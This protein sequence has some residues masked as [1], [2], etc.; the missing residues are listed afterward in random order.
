MLHDYFTLLHE[1]KHENA[2]NLITPR[3]R[4]YFKKF[5]K[6]TT[7]NVPEKFTITAVQL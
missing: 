7:Y 4:K 5:F 3:Q 6:D 1:K 2:L